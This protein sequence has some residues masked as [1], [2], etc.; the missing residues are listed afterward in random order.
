M[1][2]KMPAGSVAIFPFPQTHPGEANGIK[3]KGIHQ[4]N[5]IFYGH[6]TTQK[7]HSRKQLG[8]Y[9]PTF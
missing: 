5:Q 1:I 3:E 8:F 2:D 7:E 4:Q 9:S 6:T